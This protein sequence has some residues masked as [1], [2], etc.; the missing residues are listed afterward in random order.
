MEDNV[1]FLVAYLIVSAHYN[2]HRNVQT[3]VRPVQV[4]PEALLQPVLT[5]L[6]M[7]QTAFS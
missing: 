1:M 2:T 6:E 4:V 7:L 3:N 5:D